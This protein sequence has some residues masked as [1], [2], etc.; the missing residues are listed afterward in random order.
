VDIAA[1]YGD[2]PARPVPMLPRPL[3]SLVGRADAVREVAAL[4]GAGRLV[5][6]A[7]PGGSGK[8]R[9]AVAV[10]T[11]L[12]ESFGGDVFFVDFAPVES[13]ADLARLAGVALDALRLTRRRDRDTATTLA[14]ALTGQPGLVVFDNCEHVVTGAAALATRLLDSADGVRLLATSQ[15]PL[16]LDGEAVWRV[17]PLAA[18]DEAAPAVELFRTRMFERTGKRMDATYLA[19]AVAI[20]GLV[21]GLPLAVELAAARAALLSVPEVRRLLVDRFRVLADAKSAGPGHHRSLRAALDWSYQLLTGPERRLLRA[22]AVFRGG[23]IE[24]AAATLPG[25]DP[26]LMAGLVAKSLINTE[27]I[28]RSRAGMLQTVS[29]Y[30]TARLAEHPDED[31]AVRAAHAAY[32]LDLAERA[33][34]QLRG[35]DQRTWLT[36]LTGEHDNLSAAMA[37]LAAQPDRPD[38]LRLATALTTFHYLTGRYP[39]GR[40]W[41]GE[42]LSR[43]PD[44]PAALRI[45]AYADAAQLAVLESDYAVGADLARRALSDSAALPDRPAYGQ[46][47]MLLGGLER[48]RAR[49]D[50]SRAHFAAVREFFTRTGNLIGTGRA[51]IQEAFTAWLAGDSDTAEDLLVEG[52]AILGDD[53]DDEIRASVELH[54]GTIALFRGDTEVAYRY[55]TGALDRFTGIAFPEGVAWALDMLARLQL[56][57]AGGSPDA[58]ELAEAEQRLRTSLSI[59]RR[60]GDRWRTAS[61]LEALATA[62]R[63]AGDPVRAAALLGAADAVRDAIGAPTPA[64]ELPERERTGTELRAGLG[65]PGF[66]AAY[67]RGRRTSVDDLLDPDRPLPVAPRAA[68]EAGAAVPPAGVAPS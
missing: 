35:P 29:D 16:G 60:L 34:A 49:Y 44:A 5:T 15:Q 55:V 66:T 45:K 28:G 13:S 12:S 47:L 41:L 40:R 9:L 17:G 52:E 21:D 10:A 19:D 63:L 30:A 20:C 14:D 53:I 2:R 61:V 54:H 3:N 37:W 23:W 62:R 59:H 56:R 33:A 68:P 11:E 7:G 38:D 4:V 48:E 6:L 32:H 43:R 24:A 64:C 25:Y 39:Q 22:L 8:T 50:G 31:R 1:A 46:L 42:A 51:A 27:L 18:G 36:T 67:R 58:A 26:D 57:G 65:E